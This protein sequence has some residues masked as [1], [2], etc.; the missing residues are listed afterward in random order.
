MRKVAVIGA[1]AAGLTATKRLSEPNSGCECCTFEQSDNVG[2]TWVYTDKV[3]KDE[4]GIPV[5]SSMYQGL[6]T[7]L[8]K[9]IMALPDLPHKGKSSKSYV[10]S[11]EVLDYFEEYADQFN[12]RKYMK[13]RHRVNTVSPM[14]NG[15]WKIVVTDLKQQKTSEC[16]FD[17]VVI[18]IGNYSN[19]VYPNVKGMESFE[20]IQIHSHDYKEPLIFRNKNV[21]VIGAGPSGLDISTQIS[22]HANKVYLSHHSEKAKFIDFP[23]NVIQKPDLSEISENEI[24]FSDG[25]IVQADAIVYCTDRLKWIKKC[26]TYL[27][28][29]S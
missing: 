12:L 24:T 10:T 4:Y 14:P 18:C 3:G 26:N 6:R 9:E 8:P 16:Y 29:Y 2:G 21:V 22:G 11:Q 5:H 7:N 27:P 15:Q 1:G 20:G 28:V 23:E 13:F 19:S 25:S 17:A